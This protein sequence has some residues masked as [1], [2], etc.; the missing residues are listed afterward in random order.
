[1]DIN[2]I[3]KQQREALVAKRF[4]TDFSF[5]SKYALKIRTK[6]GTT[7]NLVL[8][9]AQREFERVIKEQVDKTG[10][11]RIIIL[12]G[13]QQGLSTVVG[14]YLYHNI[15]L[16]KSKKALVVAHDK[17]AATTLFEMT[18]R[19]HDNNPLDSGTYPLKPK[20]KYDSKTEIK[21]DG[22]DSS[23]MI[24]TAGGDGIVRGETITHAHLSEMAFWPDGTAEDNFNGLMQSIPN[25]DDTAVFIE[26]TANGVS[27]PFYRLWQDAVAGNN[28]FYPLFIPWYWETGYREAILPNEDFTRTPH[29]DELVAKFGLDNEQLKWRRFK[30]AVSGP[31]KFQQEYPMTP[32]EAFITSGSGVFDPEPLIARQAALKDGPKARKQWIVDQ[33]VN[34]PEGDLHIYRDPLPG[35]TYYIGADVSMGNTSGNTTSKGDWSVAQV[36]DAHG[37]QV[38][39]YR[40]KPLPDY[41]AV[42]L[43]QLGLMYNRAKIAVEANNHGLLTINKLYKDLNYTNVHYQKID[44]KQV[45]ID[46]DSLG[47]RTTKKSKLT[48]INELRAKLRDGAIELNDKTTINELL[49]YIVR[50]EDKMGAENG[51]HDDCVMALAF[52]N[53]INKGVWK[54]IINQESW[55]VEYI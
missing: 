43:K 6:K 13:R 36:L 3:S 29:E 50:G 10:R 41:Y 34:R 20:T 45:D 18:K 25:E 28:D 42:I 12:K 19:Y 30:V 55:Y 46:T 17:R 27:G 14:A 5:F 15:S 49:T 1:M 11:V 7:E 35:E 21:F 40:G 9:E 31:S 32:D 52:A 37:R 24:A 39:V 33:W 51:C 23:Y 53:H 4:I 47:F 48:I 16:K 8:N 38:A 44:D 54:P 2:E 22:L 26:S